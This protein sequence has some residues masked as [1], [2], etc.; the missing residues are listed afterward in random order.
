[1]VGE[2]LEGSIGE[3]GEGVNMSKHVARP[4][5]ARE[6]IPEEGLVLRSSGTFAGY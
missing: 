6:R 2:S 1:M 5:V 4:Q 3:M